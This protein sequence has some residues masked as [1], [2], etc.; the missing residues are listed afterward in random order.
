MRRVRAWPVLCL[1]LGVATAGAAP[2]QLVVPHGRIGQS[3]TAGPSAL[4]RGD[5]ALF[6]I[7][8]SGDI[9][10]A[11]GSVQRR[12]LTVDRD[13][14]VKLAADVAWDAA[15]ALP[16]AGNRNIFSSDRSGATFAFDWASLPPATRSLLDQPEA[17]AAADGLGEL[18]T[19]FLRGERS[20]EGRFRK[21]AGVLGDIVNSMPLI[22]GAPPPSISDSAYAAFRER[23]KQRDLTV[24][25][26]AN[27]GMLHAFSAATGAE[28]FAYVPEALTAN[29]SLLASPAYKPRPWVD[30][31]AAHG[32]VR[33]GAGWRTVLAVGMGMGARGVFALD[34]TDPAHFARGMGALWEFSDADDPAMGHVR[35]APLIGKVTRDRGVKGAAEGYFAIVSSGINKLAPGGG[36]LFLLALDKPAGAAWRRGA[37]Y[38]GIATPAGSAT[39]AN[40]LSSPALVVRSDG[41]ASR[42]Y[43]GDLLGDLW[44][45]D[46]SSMSAHRL[47]TARDE[48]GA[49]QPI[50]HAPKVVFAPG[51]GYLILFATGKLIEESDLLPSS[52]TP[53]SVYAI[54]D[55]PGAEHESVASRS[56]LA[57]RKLSTAAT[58]YAISGDG[59]AYYGPDAKKGWYFDFPNTRNDGE[60][61]AASPASIEGAIVIASILPATASGRLYVV[62]ALTGFAYDPVSG[63]KPDAATGQLHPLDPALPLLVI[64]TA[65]STGE[66]NATGG[67]VTT[68]QVTLAGPNAG[69]GLKFDVRYPSGRLG[70]REVSN[71]PELHRA[72]AGKRR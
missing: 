34:I 18:R 66:R 41:S 4:W 32:E 2:P 23:F 36:T 64:D 63:T 22:V 70:W 62:D 20:E 46:F 9:P 50:A 54:L 28:L 10:K 59:F 43:A 38:F 58:G 71:W 26:G 42:A 15:L 67:A 14:A 60:R 5:G 44:R 68:R 51:G 35:E 21:R 69:A 8:T 61:A 52:F 55:A 48:G 53:Q 6:V 57:A 25:I 40:A 17:G 31:S 29:L 24:Y 11:F 13:G 1:A 27:D 30:G 3:G 47:F 39:M 19:A 33:I 72:A 56:Q 49:P 37:N 65:L 7:Q 16:A 45:F 12:A